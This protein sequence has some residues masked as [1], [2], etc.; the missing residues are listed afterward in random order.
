MPHLDRQG[1]GLAPV[2]VGLRRRGTAAAARARV[3]PQTG[4][5]R[6]EL[7]QVGGTD[8]GGLRELLGGVQRRSGPV[9]PPMRGGRRVGCVQRLAR[10]GEDDGQQTF[11]ERRAEVGNAGQAPEAAVT[12]GPQGDVA[13][14][15]AATAWRTA[16]G[17]AGAVTHGRERRRRRRGQQPSREP[18]GFPAN[19]RQE[20]RQKGRRRRLAA[21]GDGWQRQARTRHKRQAQDGC[22]QLRR[23]RGCGPAQRDGRRRGPPAVGA[24]VTVAAGDA[25]RGSVAP[26]GA[27]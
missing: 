3:P 22:R 15:G 19:G 14:T 2:H 20:A 24:R 10:D 26:A 23:Q 13:D 5:Q 12:R 1:R 17:P 21:A 8:G 9:A 7:P 16:G 25:G 4:Q 18:G 27:P 6:H 11:G